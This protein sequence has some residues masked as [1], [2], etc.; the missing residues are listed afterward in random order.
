[1]LDLSLAAMYPFGMLP[2]PYHPHMHDAAR[3]C[4]PNKHSRFQKTAWRQLFSASASSRPAG[5]KQSTDPGSSAHDSIDPA[6]L[7]VHASPNSRIARPSATIPPRGSPMDDPGAALLAHQRAA[8]VALACVCDASIG[9]SALRAKH[10]ACDLATGISVVAHALA[11]ADHLHLSFLPRRRL[12][13][14]CAPRAPPCDP[15]G[16]PRAQVSRWQLHGTHAL[17]Q[18]HRTPQSQECEIVIQGAGVV[19]WVRDDLRCVA[20]LL[21]AAGLPGAPFP[22]NNIYTTLVNN[23]VRSCE[24]PVGGDQHSTTPWRSAGLIVQTHLMSPLTLLGWLPVHDGDARV[25]STVLCDTSGVRSGHQHRE[26]RGAS[27]GS[28][29]NQV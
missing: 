26:H 22:S 18:G 11:V 9:S 2:G 16:R 25:A 12:A 24:N 23:A 27:H 3:P 13:A 20:V 4:K 7:V 15:A 21:V 17:V 29:Q 5:M 1:M 14:A 10:A 28:N 6:Q 8:A 19:L